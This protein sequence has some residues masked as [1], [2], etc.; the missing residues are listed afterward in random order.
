MEKKIHKSIV[1]ILLHVHYMVFYELIKGLVAVRIFKKSIFGFLHI[2]IVWHLGN[3]IFKFQIDSSKI[4]WVMLADNK[5]FHSHVA[6]TW[7]FKCVFLETMF[8]KSVTT[9]T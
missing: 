9:I 8:F 7:N 3:M 5:K 1:I 2:L 4:D 6:Y